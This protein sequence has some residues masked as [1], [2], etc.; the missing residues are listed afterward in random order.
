M[1]SYAFIFAV[2]MAFFETRTPLTATN[3]SWSMLEICSSV[4]K[5]VWQAKLI[6]DFLRVSWLATYLSKMLRVPPSLCA[7][8]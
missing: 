1:I 4:S 2:F 3:I 6:P 7:R 8:K 5:A